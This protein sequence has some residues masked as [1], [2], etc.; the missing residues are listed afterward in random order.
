MFFADLHCDFLSKAALGA[1]FEKPE[2]GQAISRAAVEGGGLRLLGMAAFC[3]D[4]QML[5]REEMAASVKAQL[6]AYEAVTEQWN[7][8]RYLAGTQVRALLTLEGLDY[9]QSAQELEAFLQ[10]G[11]ASAGLMWNRANAL[12]GSVHE[13]APLTAMGR[14]IV[15]LLERCGVKVDLA[16]A[17]RRTFYDVMDCCECPFVSH[18][19]VYSVTEHPR[20][21]DDAQIRRLIER[22]GLLGISF[23]VPFA[24]GDTYGQLRRHI[25]HVL[26]LGGQDILA[27]GSDFDGC[28]QT[29]RGLDTAEKYPA[30]AEYLRLKGMSNTVLEKLCFGNAAAYFARR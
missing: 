13:D 3:G 14:E 28:D 15:E 29:V 23:Y 4:S 27:F 18:A 10:K 2:S 9:L 26:D 20:N 16:H 22:K 24:G 19:N 5:S 21:L 1:S 8:E 17:G 11:V 30:F 6:E 25:E 12:G 7:G